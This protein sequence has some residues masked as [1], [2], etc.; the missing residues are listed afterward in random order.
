MSKFTFSYYLQCVIGNKSC[1]YSYKVT[2]SVGWTNRI[3]T[4]KCAGSFLLCLFTRD[5]VKYHMSYTK[6]TGF[7]NTKSIVIIEIK[8]LETISKHQDIRSD[9]FTV[10]STRHT[11]SQ[12]RSSARGMW[13]NRARNSSSDCIWQFRAILWKHK[14]GCHEGKIRL[15]LATKRH[16]VQSVQDVHTFAQAALETAESGLEE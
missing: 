3:L 2:I 14:E 16:P 8:E 13:A 1:D 10:I 12:Q 11:P 15:C 4:M 9:V 6:N 5:Y 7:V